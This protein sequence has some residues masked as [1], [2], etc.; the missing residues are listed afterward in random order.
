[1]SDPV[2]PQAD[3]PAVYRAEREPKAL[4]SSLSDIISLADSEKEA[5]GFL[6]PSAYKDAIEKRRLVGMFSISG[7]DAK[8]VGYVLF[9]GV[10]PN[11][12]IQQIVVDKSHRRGRVA[13]SLL[14]E[15]ISQLEIRGYLTLTAAVASDLRAAQELYEEN[16]FVAK[17]SRKGGKVR[18]RQIILRARDLQTPSLFS[19]FEPARSVSRGLEG[20]GLRHRGAGSAPLYAIDL[21]VLFDVTKQPPRPRAPFA[22]RLITAALSHKVRLVI[23][24]E[25]IAEL[26]RKSE[27]LDVDPILRLALQLPRLP[28][29]ESEEAERIA[30]LLHRLIFEEPGMGSAGTP[31]ARSDA[32]HLAEAALASATAYVTSDGSILDVR[33]EILRE[34]GVDVCSLEE[35]VELLPGELSSPSPTYV[36]ETDVSIGDVS[37][38]VSRSYLLGRELGPE[39]LSEFT[40]KVVDTSRW[41][42]RA[43]FEG[44]E[45]VGAGIYISPPYIHTPARILV[46]V[47]PD[48]VAADR[49]VDHLLDEGVRRASAAGPATIEL[50]WVPGQT[51]VRKSAMLRGF[52]PNEGRGVLIKGAIGRPVTPN[53]WDKFSRQLR[54]ATSLQLPDDPPSLQSARSG[55]SISNPEGEKSSIP[56]EILE[57][58]LGPTLVLLPGRDG[59]IVPITRSFADDLLNT[60]NQMSLFGE[61]I[62]ALL[63]QR[64]YFNTPRAARLM[65]PRTPILF[66]ESKRSGGRGNIVAAARIVDSMVMIKDQIPKEF[67][68]SAVVE[69]L[70]ALTKTPDIL[71]T[72]FDSLLQ[73]PRQ[74]SLEE[75]RTMNAVGPSNLQTVT[76]LSSTLLCQILERGWE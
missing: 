9:S 29:V 65:R 73:F 45:V 1:M 72:T 12:K 62:A 30:K 13:T 61:P 23:A 59:V 28:V 76:A 3:A 54:R 22:D 49:F 31:Q 41:S 2:P 20:L 58:A 36:K 8:L 27:G 46:H 63:S 6:P 38:D 26:N 24:P 40:P 60:G 71:V 10:Y 68:T 39:Y 34:I 70:G 75:L 50:P 56:L 55:V 5:L 48:H 66:Y 33:R 74:I 43:V 21:N 18:K 7:G 37:V 4:L 42:G 67:Y 47:R 16:G 17:R 44:E 64:T 25:F 19:L 52:V 15:I 11:A 35:F 57:D 69:D 53:S 14:N 51:T 32:R